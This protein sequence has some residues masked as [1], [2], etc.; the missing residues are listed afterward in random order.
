MAL[1]PGSPAIDAG[2]AGGAPA[3]DQRGVTRPQGPGVDIGAF[4]YQYIPIFT[5]M[6][7]QS[8]TNCALQMCGL[9]PTQTFTLQVS[10]NLLNW[11]AVTNFTG[12]NGFI[13]YVD[14]TAGKNGKRFYRLKSVTQ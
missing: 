3:T 2:S 7:I 9:L 12:T 4:E 8:A 10:S 13:Q 6:T 5:S 11:S 1:L 14:P